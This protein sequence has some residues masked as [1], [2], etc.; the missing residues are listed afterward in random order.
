VKK[1]SVNTIL[2]QG[3][4]RIPCKKQPYNQHPIDIKFNGRTINEIGGYWNKKYWN[5]SKM[6][7]RKEIEKP[8]LEHLG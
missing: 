5:R 7:P 2:Y 8:I 3:P 6:N 1:E 4:K